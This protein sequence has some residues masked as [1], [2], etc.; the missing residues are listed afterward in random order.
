VGTD[1]WSIIDNICNT[2]SLEISFSFT[3]IFIIF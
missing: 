3:L 1:H 2:L